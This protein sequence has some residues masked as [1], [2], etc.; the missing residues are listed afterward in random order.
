MPPTEE[1]PD[2]ISRASVYKRLAVLVLFYLFVAHVLPALG[3]SLR[4]S[5]L[6]LRAA[7]LALLT[8]VVRLVVQFVEAA[9]PI[10][11]DERAVALPRRARMVARRK[12]VGHWAIKLP[13]LAV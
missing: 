5:V 7:V 2:R 6:G 3:F 8:E 9:M 10:V 13:P 1:K 12:G 11:L 4:S